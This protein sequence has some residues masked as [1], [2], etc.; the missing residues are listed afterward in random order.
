MAHFQRERPR[1]RGTLTM[2]IYNVY[3]ANH[4]KR[5]ARSLW[6]SVGY[7]TSAGE[8]REHERLRRRPRSQ[9]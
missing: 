7:L 5:Y 1:V 2:R 6:L 4:Q 8:R 9:G 3:Y